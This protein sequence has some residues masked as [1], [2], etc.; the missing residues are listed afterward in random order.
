MIFAKDNFDFVVVGGGAVGLFLAERLKKRFPECSICVLEKESK[1]AMHTSGRNSGVLHAGI[2][3]EPRTEK[4]KVCV[5]GAKRLAHWIKE[6]GLPLNECGK[7]IVA[8]DEHLDSQIDV[9]KKRAEANGADVEIIDE[10]HAKE[11]CPQVRVI[12]GRGLWSPHT[13]VTDPKKVLNY[14]TSYLYSNKCSILYNFKCSKID[15]K[16]RY[17]KAIDGR[18]IGYGYLFNCAG[19]YANDIA[20]MFDVGKELVAIPF[21]G[22][23]WKLKR[24]SAIQIKTNIYPVPDLEFPFLGVHFSP[25][26]DKSS[27]ISVG[28][29]ATVAWGRE[30]YWNIENIEPEIAYNNIVHLGEQYIRNRSNFRKYVHEQAPLFYKPLMVK[31]AKKLIPDIREND[32]EISEKVGIR[33][34]LFNTATKKLEHDFLYS[35]STKSTH[36]LNAISPAFTASF[37]LSDLII[38]KSLHNL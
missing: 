17:I 32:L 23:Y 9:L 5:K 15:G 24:E 10:R 4:A 3:Y 26:A 19:H 6:H 12:S 16:R 8:Q 22:M 2:Y 30:N 20:G 29:T 33:P 35:V 34:Q 31:Q 13:K 7:L 18:V 14:L 37:E 38:D 21:K 27:D 1:T 28:P 25:G 36:V 11:L